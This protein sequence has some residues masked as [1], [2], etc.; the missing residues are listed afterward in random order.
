[1]FCTSSIWSHY[2]STCHSR[3]CPLYM[4]SVTANSVTQTYLHAK[5]S[6][7]LHLVL[8]PVNHRQQ[9]NQCHQPMELFL[10]NRRSLIP[11]IVNRSWFVR[12]WNTKVSAIHSNCTIFVTRKGRGIKKVI[13][14][15]CTCATVSECRCLVAGATST[16]SPRARIENRLIILSCFLLDRWG[17][18]H[19]WRVQGTVRNYARKKLEM[20]VMVRASLLP[21]RITF[22][23]K[24]PGTIIRGL[25]GSFPT[26][27]FFAHVIKDRRQKWR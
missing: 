5:S 25:A 24:K 11:T 14:T 21:P 16:I 26:F 4:N 17:C 9:H 19:A 18:C 23:F 13:I 3:Q 2:W 7:P 15:L 12:H 20:I 1:M 8:H 10:Q 27:H 22:T 6:S